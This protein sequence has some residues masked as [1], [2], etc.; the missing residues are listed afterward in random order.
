MHISQ[1]SHLRTT[2]IPIQSYST[3]LRINFIL[4]R[5]SHPSRINIH[6]EVLEQDAN[7]I[8]LNLVSRITHKRMGASENPKDKIVSIFMFSIL[9]LVRKLIRV[10]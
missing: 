10:R 9:V 5:I 7:T 1:L 2:N 8:P 3:K 6:V 4:V